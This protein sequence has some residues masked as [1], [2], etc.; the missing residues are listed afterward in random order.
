MKTP[1]LDVKMRATLKRVG[2]NGGCEGG[3]GEVGNILNVMFLFMKSTMRS[4]QMILRD[5]STGNEA[6]SF[7]R[8]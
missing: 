8:G 7:Q 2:K 6:C 1:E 3:A 4:P 5:V